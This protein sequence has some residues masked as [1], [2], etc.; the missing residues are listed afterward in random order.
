MEYFFNI[1]KLD[2]QKKK[3]FTH[4]DKKYFFNDLVNAIK[5]TGINE[6]DIVFVHSDVGKFGKLGDIKNRYEFN[7]FF[8]NACLKAIGKNG[9]LIVPTFT[10]SFCKDE[11]FDINKSPS[12]LNYFTEVARNTS[13]FQRSEDPLFSVVS[14]GPA[15]KNIIENISDDCFGKN[16]VWDRM[17]EMNV[18][19][20]MIGTNFDSAFIHYVE[21]MFKVPYRYDKK[22]EGI[23]K[24]NG[25]DFKKTNNYFVRNLKL[26]PE[27]TR[28]KLF[29]LAKKEKV[30]TI[31]KL[32][33]S[34]IMNIKSKD[35]FFICKKLLERDIFALV[36]IKKVNS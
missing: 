25:K 4:N 1:I 15:T 35:L 17:N 29:E 2:M 7:S 21:T 27:P 36:K 24:I 8:L 5:K 33:N 13:G 16:S 6:G 31:Q 30:I 28:I 10:Y 23:T 34:K 9:T 20:L 19:N 32:G 22:F 11:I 3:I 12:K 14:Y 26:N 18:N